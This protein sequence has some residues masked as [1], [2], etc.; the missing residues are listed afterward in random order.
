VA[1]FVAVSVMR[2]SSVPVLLIAAPLSIVSAWW[3]QRVKKSRS[4]I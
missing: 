2:V 1:A 3:S 4:L